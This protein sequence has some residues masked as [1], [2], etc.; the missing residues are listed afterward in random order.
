MKSVKIRAGVK[1]DI[2]NITLVEQFIWVS[3]RHIV[4]GIKNFCFLTQFIHSCRIFLF[5]ETYSSVVK[6]LP[7]VQEPQETWVWSLGLEDP[8]EEEL[9]LQYSCLEN[10]V[11]RGAWWV[12]VCGVAKSRTR[13]SGLAQHGMCVVHYSLQRTFMSI[14]QLILTSIIWPVMMKLGFNPWPSLSSALLS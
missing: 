8:V 9:A 13:L 1:A 14:T 4:D 2:C 3:L 11:D 5:S 7:A 12:R 6:N 10:P